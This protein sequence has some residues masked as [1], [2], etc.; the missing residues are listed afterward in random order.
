MGAAVKL[1]SN[2]SSM[3]FKSDKYS[4]FLPKIEEKLTATKRKYNSTKGKL[5]KLN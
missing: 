4:E 2:R 3:M 1:S 5:V